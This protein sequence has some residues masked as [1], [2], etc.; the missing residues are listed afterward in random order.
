MEALH[1]C[2][3]ILVVWYIHNISYL[4]AIKTVYTFPSHVSVRLLTVFGALQ[5]A[6]GTCTER[7]P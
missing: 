2:G 6:L 4:F 3:H 1:S 7:R 5:S